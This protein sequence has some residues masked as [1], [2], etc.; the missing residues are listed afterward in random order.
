MTEPDLTAT[1]T[2]TSTGTWSLDPARTLIEIHTKALR[3]IKVKGTAK[4]L[5]GTATVNGDDTVAGGIV[6]DTASIDTG[7]KKRDAH[8][9]AA[10]FFEV[11]KYPTIDFT[12]TDGR[13]DDEGKAQL[14]G[15]LA[16]HGMA[17]PIAFAADVALD[18]KAAVLTAA[19]DID[20]SKWGVSW[21]KMG[22]GLENR[23]LITAT[24]TRD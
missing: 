10:D 9:R 16:L 8:L 5:S 4:A 12:V 24:F 18:A 14:T 11:L 1:T 7:N 6:V 13:V 15:T 21:A 19:V 23:V 2:A 20:R 22:A 3:V 17:L